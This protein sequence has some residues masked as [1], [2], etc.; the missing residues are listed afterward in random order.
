MQIQADKNE[1][2]LLA[3]FLSFQAWE[4]IRSKIQALKWLFIMHTTEKLDHE[5]KKFK[6]MGM[7]G[8]FVCEESTTLLGFEYLWH[9]YTDG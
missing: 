1:I 3:E 8:D 4:T 7:L 9:N 6:K 5:K 2:S